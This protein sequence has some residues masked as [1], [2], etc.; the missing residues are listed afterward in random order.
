VISKPLLTFFRSF[1]VDLF[2]RLD[3]RGYIPALY[4]HLH[5][6]SMKLS[7]IVGLTR[8]PLRKRLRSS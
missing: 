6:V 5:S 2:S 3:F 8:P 7:T 1:L 4:F